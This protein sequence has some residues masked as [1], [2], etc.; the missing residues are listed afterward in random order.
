[1]TIHCVLGPIP[2]T[3]EAFVVEIAVHFGVLL[4]ELARITVLKEFP[5]QSRRFFKFSDACSLTQSV[6]PC[7]FVEKAATS[8]P[9]PSSSVLTQGL[10]SNMMAY[11][12]ERTR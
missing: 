5:C 7:A 4:P 2:I 12:H 9:E 1:M 6:I 11:C 3:G 10:H 8:P